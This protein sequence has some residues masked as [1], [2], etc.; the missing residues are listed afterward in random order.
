MASR[1]IA[2]SISPW[3]A[4]VNFDDEG[5]DLVREFVIENAEYWIS[6]F[7]FDG[8]RF[9]AVHAIKETAK[10]TSWMS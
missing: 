8:L 5:S 1:K 6:E 3:G 2:A 4:A 7:H 10:H 9:D